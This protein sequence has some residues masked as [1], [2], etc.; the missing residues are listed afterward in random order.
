MSE[1]P[2]YGFHAKARFT[3]NHLA[4]YLC[5][6]NARQRTA[7]IREAK[8]PRKV[9]VASYSQIKPDIIRFLAGNS[10]DFTKLDATVERLAAKAR[11]D[12]RHSAQIEARRCIDAIEAFKE[13]FSKARAKGFQFTTG[14]KVILKLENVAVNIPMDVGVIETGGRGVTHSGGCILF[15]A[16]SADARKNIEERRKHVA[17][18]V[19]WG[20]EGG[21][22]EPL[23]RLCMSFDVFGAK[24][25]RAPASSTR[26]RAEMRD[27]CREVAARWDA[28]EPPDGYDGPDWEP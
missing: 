15:L 25:E 8:F 6:T 9:Q 20:L 22:M 28:V 19:H 26:L 11:N 1:T 24:I 27:S 21:Q 4:A 13:T 23:T 12:E 16:G 2:N 10:G 7:I 18:L 17:A 3:A 14:S 5:T